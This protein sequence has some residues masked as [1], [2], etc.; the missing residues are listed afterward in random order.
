VKSVIVIYFLILVKI[1]S[2]FSSCGC[3]YCSECFKDCKSYNVERSSC[4]S[5]Q[6][7]TDF[8]RAIDLNDK[9]S[10]KRIEFIYDDPDLL[11]RRVLDSIKVNIFYI[12]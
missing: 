4:F 9:E 12:H 7:N 10:I 5:C 8:N 6:K 11:M 1:G 2:F 3:F